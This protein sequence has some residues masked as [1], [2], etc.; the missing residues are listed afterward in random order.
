MEIS[1]AAVL[2]LGGL[3]ILRWVIIG[4]G[5][6]LVLHSARVCPAC[7]EQ[8][9]AVRRKILTVLVRIAEWRWCPQCGWEGPSRKP[10]RSSWTSRSVKSQA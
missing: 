7:F 1:L 10:E 9:V 6:L 5:S 8:T 3:V 2:V 4:L